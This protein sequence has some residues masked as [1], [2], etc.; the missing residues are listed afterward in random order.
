MGR[1]KTDLMSPV[2]MISSEKI[3]LFGGSFNP[4]HHGHLILA[5]DAMEALALDRVIFIPANVSPHK[6]GQPPAPASIRC[7]M[8]EAAIAGEARFSMD[9]CEAEREGPS[10]AIDTV[11]LMRSRFQNAEIFYFIGEDNLPALHTLARDRG[12]PTHRPLRRARTR[13][14]SG[15]QCVSGCEAPHRHFLDGYQ[16]S[17]CARP[18]GSLLAAGRRLR[19]S[20]TAPTLFE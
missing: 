12:T 8:V 6:L 20:H 19:D 15:L 7:E 10:F 4:I 9:A 2:E 3:G 5:R 16:E 11:R 17:H 13:G 14:C 18:L 1:G